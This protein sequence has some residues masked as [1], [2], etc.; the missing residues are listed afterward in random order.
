M[1]S[2]I[3]IALV[4]AAAF[5]LGTVLCRWAQEEVDWLKHKFRSKFLTKAKDFALAPVGLLGVVLA[6]ATKTKYYE[7]I[8]LCLLVVALLFGAFVV[9]EKDRK[10]TKKYIIETAVTFL[11]FFGVVY[12][13]LN[14]IS[15]C[16]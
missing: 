9:A 5:G 8:S 4:I 16:K 1:L 3:A 2:D 12:F 14:F 11:A 13:A 15:F 6:V 10:L 7:T